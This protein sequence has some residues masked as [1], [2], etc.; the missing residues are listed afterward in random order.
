MILRGGA[1][2]GNNLGIHSV[3]RSQWKFPPQKGA[4]GTDEKCC[5]LI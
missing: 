5:A 2:S 4:E 3:M 1:G